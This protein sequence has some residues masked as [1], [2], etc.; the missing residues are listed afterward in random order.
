MTETAAVIHEVHASVQ[1]YFNNPSS[2][3]CRRCCE[4]IVV[5]P[6]SAKLSNILYRK[7]WK[8]LWKNC[9]R[10]HRCFVFV[11]FRPLCVITIFL[12]ETEI[13][14][15]IHHGFPHGT[16]WNREGL[17][18]YDVR[19]RRTI[20][21]LQYYNYCLVNHGRNAI[22]IFYRRNKKKN[23]IIYKLF[24]RSDIDCTCNRTIQIYP[25]T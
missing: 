4:T 14:K 13:T 24:N 17:R 12:D 2:N 21:K 8:F 19:G 5:G 7:R 18:V 25:Y 23:E 15:K 9:I 20:D 1:N 6:R 11:R 10:A 16:R 22:V 3:R